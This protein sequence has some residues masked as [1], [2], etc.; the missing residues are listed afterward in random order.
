MIIGVIEDDKTLRGLICEVLKSYGFDVRV[1]NNAKQAIEMIQRDRP[2]VIIMDLSI[3]SI[4]DGFAVLEVV[5]N[6]SQKI[7]ICTGQSLRSQTIAEWQR[8]G[9][10]YITKPYNVFDLIPLI[11]HQ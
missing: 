10:V 4:Q 6:I 3:P 11:G 1:A 8:K 5:K 2:S 7:I 9:I